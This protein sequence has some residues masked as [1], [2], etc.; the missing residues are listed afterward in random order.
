LVVSL[1]QSIRQPSDSGLGRRST[2]EAAR[3][4][5]LLNVAM[6]DAMGSVAGDPPVAPRWINL[7]PSGVAAALAGKLVQGIE[8]AAMLKH[9]LDRSGDDRQGDAHFRTH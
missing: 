5:A 8:S 6:H 3:I 4:H 1:I 7:A 9:I 2:S